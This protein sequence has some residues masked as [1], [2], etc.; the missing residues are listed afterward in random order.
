MLYYPIK[1]DAR[2][3]SSHIYN[4]KYFNLGRDNIKHRIYYKTSTYKNSSFNFSF[5]QLFIEN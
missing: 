2:N 5:I 1:F 4:I 3:C